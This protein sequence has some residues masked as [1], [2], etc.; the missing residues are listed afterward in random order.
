[1]I[2]KQNQILC[3]DCEGSILLDSSTE[4]GEIVICKDCSVQLEVVSLQPIKVNPAPKLDEDWG[5]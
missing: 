5:E 4:K 3:P 1:M 2:N